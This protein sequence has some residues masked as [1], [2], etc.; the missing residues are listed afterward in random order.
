MPV[1]SGFDGHCGMGDYTGTVASTGIAGPILRFGTFELDLKSNELRRAGVLIKLSPQQ[2]RVLRYLAENA[3][4]VC[5]REEIQQE[6]WGTEVFVDFDRGLNVSIAQIRSALNDDS[7][8]PRFIQTVP[9]RGYRFV[10]PVEQSGAQAVEPA[11]GPSLPKTGR[12]VWLRA[13]AGLAIAAMALAGVAWKVWTSR[14]A[15]PRTML[16]VLPFQ[17]VTQVAEDAAVIDGLGDEL[18]TQ[19]GAVLPA[20]LGVIGRT[21][22]LRY[23]S[24]NPGIP[25]IGRE[26]HVDYVVEGGV[27]REGG[28]VRISARLLNVADQSQRWSETF[29][30]DGSNRLEIEERVAARVTAAV[31]RELFPSSSSPASRGHV[32]D[33]QAY[34][35]FVK[36]RYLLHNGGR[37]NAERAITEFETA[38]QHDA[39]FAEPWAAM[40]HT[41]VGIALSGAPASD[42]LAK[43]RACAE[44]A[45]RIDEGNAEAHNAL[46]DVLLWRDWKWADAQ[47]HF[48]RAIAINPSYAQAHHD[49]GFYQV[50]MGHAEAGLASLRRA[51]AIDP[52][53]PRVNVDAGWVLL[54]A[55]HFDEAIAQ[56]KRALDLDPG[57]AEAKACI[58]RAEQYQGKASP[59]MLDFFR[60][61]L[62]NPGRSSAYNLALA[63]AVLGRKEDALREL[64]AAYEGHETLMVMLGTEPSFA[65]LHSDARYRELARKVGL[66]GGD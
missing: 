21:S 27:R 66:P 10:A 37:E 47:R 31:V 13:V 22:V 56:A 62:Q 30:E 19:F 45:L 41:Y 50:V 64:Q 6:I 1:V 35:A 65:G 24:R 39:S 32:P 16:A 4:R 42:A 52:L 54:Q 33:A 28:R 63:N 14:E 40:A 60:E 5:T 38:A 53:S 8:A 26:L 17:N 15:H 44:K 23:G 51:I 61:R 9:R 49:Y 25:Q 7:D 43:A 20:R 58:A 55:H 46:A 36:G 48:E 59:Q 12:R 2:L 34:D 18:I 11:A 29:E 3:G 57:S